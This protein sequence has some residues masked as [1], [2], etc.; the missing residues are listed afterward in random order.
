MTPECGIGVYDLLVMTSVVEFVFRK[1]TS[2][3][4]KTASA[5]LHFIDWKCAGHGGTYQ[6]VGTRWK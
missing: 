5:A 1:N 2:R 3:G 4:E 6:L